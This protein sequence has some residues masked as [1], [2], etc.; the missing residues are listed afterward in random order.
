[1]GS[2]GIIFLDYSAKSKIF[3]LPNTFQLLRCDPPR[4]ERVPRRRPKPPSPSGPLVGGLPA[5][6]RA[7]I[8]G[9][10]TGVRS[11]SVQLSRAVLGTLIVRIRLR[12]LRRGKE[13]WWRRGDSNS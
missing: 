2:I 9:S 4:Q 1:M 6:G 8:R 10:M 12:W 7:R 5:D 13:G 3:N 11:A